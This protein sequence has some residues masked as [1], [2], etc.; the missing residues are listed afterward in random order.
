MPQVDLVYMAAM[1]ALTS[2]AATMEPLAHLTA[3]LDAVEPMFI[4]NVCMR[5]VPGDYC[6]RPAVRVAHQA[7]RAAV[8]RILRMDGPALPE[9]L[10]PTADSN[11]ICSDKRTK[12]PQ[13]VRHLERRSLDG[14]VP[15]SLDAVPMPCALERRYGSGQGDSS[16]PE[17]GAAREAYLDEVLPWYDAL[18]RLETLFITLRVGPVAKKVV[19]LELGDTIEYDPVWMGVAEPST[20]RWAQACWALLG[21][22]GRRDEAF[23]DGVLSRIQ[24]KSAADLLFPWPWKQLHPAI[25]I[26][27][28]GVYGFHLR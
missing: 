19:H 13:M 12:R 2:R 4:A 3:V 7:L 17:R 26:E 9:G 8:D 15:G 24:C 5:A 16:D 25:R 6:Q 1:G 18:R 23:V 27:H 22:P 21:G 14:W 28:R 11:F 20:G 10:L